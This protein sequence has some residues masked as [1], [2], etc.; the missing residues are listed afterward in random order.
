MR[1]FLLFSQLYSQLIYL[2]IIGLTTSYDLY[3]R[4]YDFLRLLTTYHRAYDFF[5]RLIIGLTTSYDFFLRLIIGLTTSS[6]SL[7][8]EFYK[9][10]LSISTMHRRFPC[11]HF[12]I[13]SIQNKKILYLLLITKI[14]KKKK[15][16]FT[17]ILVKS[18]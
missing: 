4:A 5:L 10:A 8:P 13:L 2:I 15:I 3:H 6:G 9:L 18:Q 16:E 12:V 17:Q 14:T 1:E 11:K 7:K